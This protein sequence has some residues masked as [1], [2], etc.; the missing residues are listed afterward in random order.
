MYTGKIINCTTLKNL[1]PHVTLAY[2]TVITGTCTS[3]Q[4]KHSWI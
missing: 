2:N 4:W 3:F 1:P